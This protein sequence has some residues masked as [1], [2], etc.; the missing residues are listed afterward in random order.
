[1]IAYF[2]DTSGIVKRYVIETGTTWILGLV[3]P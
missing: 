2:F 1:M 3:T